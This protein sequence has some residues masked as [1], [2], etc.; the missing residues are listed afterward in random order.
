MNPSELIDKQI[1]KL[2]DWRGEM[3]TD[4]RKLILSTDPRIT[5]DWKWSTGVWACG[6]PI[7]AVATFKDHVKI[8]FFNGAT[9]RDVNG[10][11]NG[12]LEAKKSR[13]IDVSEGGAFDGSKF[14]ELVRAAIALE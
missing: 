4:I 13:S 2:G 3:I 12:G 5:E 10:L 8:N 7:C 6:K 9:L 11:F 14:Q 1:A